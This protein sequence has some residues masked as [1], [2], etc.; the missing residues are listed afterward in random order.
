MLVAKLPS[1]VDIGII[2]N[3]SEFRNTALSLPGVIESAHMGHPDFRVGGKIFATLGAPDENYAMVKLPPQQQSSLLESC[4]DVFIACKGA[5]GRSGCTLVRLPAAKKKSIVKAA[6]EIAF[7]NIAAGVREKQSTAKRP[8]PEKTKPRA[9]SLK[10]AIV[11]KVKKRILN[12]A[13]ALPEAT[14]TPCGGDHLSLEVRGKRL[15]YFLVDHHGDGRIAINVKANP[16]VSKALAV[17]HPLRFHIPKYVGRHG[18]I[19]LWLDQP[20]VDWNEVALVMKE[21]YRLTAPKAL[22]R[23]ME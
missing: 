22:A 11:E 17:K 23:D 7:E 1:S 4:P 5:W 9:A 10:K 2:M 20:V 13:R 16:E 21:A 15:G 8:R 18:W 6:I 14:A 19:G 3:P 12:I